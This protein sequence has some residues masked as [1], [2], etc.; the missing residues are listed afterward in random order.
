M[1]PRS[2]FIKEDRKGVILR[3]ENILKLNEQLRVTAAPS[4]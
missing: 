2:G 1:V 3:I 4:K